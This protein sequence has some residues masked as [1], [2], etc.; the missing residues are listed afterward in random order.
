MSR[1]KLDT[2]I[3][4]PE[5]FIQYKCC[6]FP[7]GTPCSNIKKSNKNH[8]FILFQIYSYHCRTIYANMLNCRAARYY[9]YSLNMHICTV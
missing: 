8:V 6:L 3:I 2:F 9:L 4:S 1:K 7:K 5:I